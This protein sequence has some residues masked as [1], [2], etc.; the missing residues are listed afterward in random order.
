MIGARDLRHWTELARQYQLRLPRSDASCSSGALEHWLRKTGV[1][2]DVYL[3]ATGY[4]RL[5][6]F[7]R[8]KPDWSLQGF[9]GLLLELRSE[10][11]EVPLSAFVAEDI[12]PKQMSLVA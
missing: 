6:D 3:E 4:G 8:L 1:G 7:P 9:V 12:G 5:S 2:R 11:D 10:R